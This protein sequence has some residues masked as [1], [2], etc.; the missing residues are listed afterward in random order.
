MKKLTS[1]G[2]S[3]EEV[4]LPW[5]RLWNISKALSMTEREFLRTTLRKLMLLW[6]DYRD[7]KGINEPEE[8]KVYANDIF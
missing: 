5:A 1:Q 6:D 7:F 4:I 8:K 2:S 3:K